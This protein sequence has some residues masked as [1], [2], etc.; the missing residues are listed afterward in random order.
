MKKLIVLTL[1]IALSLGICT[2]GF[3]AEDEMV[4]EDLKAYKV[5]DSGL[6]NEEFE[7]LE[8]KISEYI[9]EAKSNKTTGFIEPKMSIPRSIL[10]T[11]EEI[12]LEY[13]ESSNYEEYE[14]NDTMKTADK[15]YLDE[16][17][18]GTIEDRND[19]DYYKIKFPQ[20]GQAYFRLV[21]P[22]NLDYDLYLLSSSGTVFDE[23]GNGDGETE[24]I[25][26]FVNPDEYYYIRVEGFG[27]SDYDNSEQY[28]IRVRFYDDVDEYAFIVGAD[29]S[30]YAPIKSDVYPDIK[31]IDTT[32]AARDVR[33]VLKNTDYY[34]T[35][36]IDEPSFGELDDT[37]TDGTDRLGSSIVFIDGH[38]EP[39]HIK[40]YYNDSDDNPV[41]CGVSTNIGGGEHIIKDENGDQESIVEFDYTRLRDKEIDSRLM[42]FAACRTADEP[43][44]SSKKNLPE[45]ATDRG[46]ECSIGWVKSSPYVSLRGWTRKF[47]NHLM[48]GYTVYESALFADEEYSSNDDVTSWKIYGNED[49]IIW[50]GNGTPISR[51]SIMPM[52][53]EES[54]NRVEKYNGITVSKNQLSELNEYITDSYE[55]IDIN[56]YEITVKE[57]ENGVLQIYYEKYINDFNTNTGFYAVAKD[58]KIIYL[59][60]KENELIDEV[61]LEISKVSVSDKDIE[62]A[63]KE[64]KENIS[65]KHM[66]SSQNISKE[67]IDGKYCLTVYTEYIVD[68]GADD[69]TMGCD[70]Y[71]Y[72]L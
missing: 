36:F 55:N 46:A 10:E 14:P 28:K 1:T 12:D 59:K 27:K 13:T 2:V 42:V 58:N 34:K 71:I 47:F 64:A 51:N 7:T 26:A 32:D 52:N 54:V 31:E 11:D 66:I 30:T 23:S 9:I 65:D 19:V 70:K 40:F 17:I 69:E 8:S 63:K 22:D 61:Y 25:Y 24:R 6:D 67:I 21:V 62:N 37:N 29:F 5:D 33:N 56:D 39:I 3:S 44:N 48:D 68:Y 43:E 4:N 41:V 35:V 57:R 50:S 38:G 15:L 16:Y 72:V 18:Y 45:Y 49:C 20:M 60:E 53:I